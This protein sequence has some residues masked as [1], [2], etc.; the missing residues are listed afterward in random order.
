MMGYIHIHVYG[1]ECSQRNWI[2]YISTRKKIGFA[3]RNITRKERD[4]L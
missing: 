1:I 3:L 4:V 2:N